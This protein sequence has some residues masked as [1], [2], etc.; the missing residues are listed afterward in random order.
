MRGKVVAAL[1]LVTAVLGCTIGNNVANCESAN[2]HRKIAGCTAII[3]SRQETAILVAAFGNRGIAYDDLGQY[4]LAI[5]DDDQAIKLAPNDARL[6]SNRGKAYG[7]KSQL[8][9]A[10]EDFDQAIKLDPNY[11]QAFVNRGFAYALEGQYDRALQDLDQAIKLDPSN[12]QPFGNRGFTYLK[13]KRP[14]SAIAAYDDALRITSNYP[15]A[16]YG[17]GLAKLMKGDTA[18]ADADFAAA[19]RLDPQVVSWFERYGVRGN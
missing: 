14:D 18:G 19:K 1:P 16:L 15:D 4:D 2:P 7:D 8:D 12:Y 3:Q 17:R 9:R 10:I 5:Q 13:M 11:A 6:Y